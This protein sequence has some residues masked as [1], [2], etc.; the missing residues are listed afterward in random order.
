MK[1]AMIDGG[2]ERALVWV[3]ILVIVVGGRGKKW[4]SKRKI[5]ADGRPSIGAPPET[6]LRGPSTTVVVAEEVVEMGVRKGLVGARAGV[7]AIPVKTEKYTKE[8]QWQVAVEAFEHNK[9]K[10]KTDQ[11][12]FTKAINEGPKDGTCK[13]HHRA[14]VV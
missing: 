14:H 6:S 11:G 8:V 3:R 10:P 5:C 1:K 13:V 4:R 12:F 2:G 9:S 7:S